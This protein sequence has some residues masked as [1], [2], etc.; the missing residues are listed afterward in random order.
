MVAAAFIGPGTVTTATFAGSSYGFTLLWAVLFSI[1]ATLLLQEM[2][3]RLGTT[4]QMGLGEAI[5]YKIRHPA[6]KLMGSMLVIVAIFVGNAA[7]EAGNISGAVLGLA[8]PD[9]VGS[10]NPWVLAIGLVAFLLLWQG[11]YKLIEKALM[12]LVGTMG[13]V[14]L[15]SALCLKPNL[16]DILRGLF[17]PSVPD[18][19]LV[20]I[21]S[22]IGT[23]VVPYNLFL[24]ASTAKTRWSDSDYSAARLDT[25]ISVLGGGVITMAILITSAMAVDASGGI[26]GIGDLASQLTPLLGS[27][28]TIFIT[29]GFLAA[30]LSSAITA[31]LAAS[32]ATTEVMGWDSNLKSSPFRIIW[33]LVLITGMI[34]SSLGFKPTL[35]ILFAQFAN[36]LLLPLLALLLLWIMNDTK[37][38]GAGTNSKW[39]NVCGILVII[40]TVILGIKSMTGAVNSFW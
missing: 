22:L 23:T 18:G 27:W 33:G 3:A 7:Y 11:K 14:F 21:I 32:Y 17:Y 35:V 16:P 20:M 34:F 13:L 28:S 39:L 31:P 37:I 19:S 4:G 36:G 1:L 9:L 25:I 26:N 40:V 6:A 24:H 15:V 10:F 2:A 5:R 38:M 12:F 8:V 29:T 30:G